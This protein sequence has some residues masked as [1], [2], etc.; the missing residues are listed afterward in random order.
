MTKKK[1]RKSR[2]GDRSFGGETFDRVGH[3]E[4]HRR[5]K[6]EAQDYRDRGYK[7]RIVDRG[8]FD[9]DIYRSRRKRR[10]RQKVRT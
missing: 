9:Y 7:A 10:K 2:M 3:E 6:K 8:M 4:T 1:K 5:A